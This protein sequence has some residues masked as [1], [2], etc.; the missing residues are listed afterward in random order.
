MPQSLIGQ[1]LSAKEEWGTHKKREK[2]MKNLNKLLFVL[3]VVTGTVAGSSKKSTAPCKLEEPNYNKN[4]ETLARMATTIRTSKKKL[5]SSDA[6]SGLALNMTKVTNIVECMTG[7]GDNAR[8]LLLAEVKSISGEMDSMRGKSEQE[9]IKQLKSLSAL[10]GEA[11]EEY[12]P[13]SQWGI[14]KKPVDPFKI[15]P[16]DSTTTRALKNGVKK[17]VD[18]WDDAK[19]AWLAAAETIKASKKQS[20]AAEA[21][22]KPRQ[23]PK[24]G[25]LS[26]KLQKAE[27]LEAQAKE[28]ASKSGKK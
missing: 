23:S 2:A 26:E 8:K 11:L 7:I 15:N 12:Q 21:A 1:R 18:A 17:I 25:S 22:Q 13:T 28:L 24:P 5:P 6:F 10:A 3:L 14:F 16:S 27:R 19:S 4:I 9:K 20:E